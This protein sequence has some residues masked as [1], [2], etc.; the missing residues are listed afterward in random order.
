MHR[1]PYILQAPENK[2]Y[3]QM[4][5]YIVSSHKVLDVEN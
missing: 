2:Y 3:T 5:I 1:A 4:T